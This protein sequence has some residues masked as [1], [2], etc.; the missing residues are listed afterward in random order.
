M[1]GRDIALLL[2][3]SAAAGCGFQVGAGN[4]GSADGGPDSSIDSSIDVAIDAPADTITVLPDG[5]VLTG[6]KRRVK[7]SFKNATRNLALDGFIALVVIDSM[8]VDYTAIKAGGANIRFTD[9]DNTSL[10]YQID[11]WTQGGTS[12]IWVRVP[13]INASSDTDYIYM[14]YG[15]PALNDAQNAAAV[16]AGQQGVWHLSQ[17]PGPGTAAAIRDS[18]P[19][20]RHGTSTLPMV[21]A[22]LV[23]AIIGNGFR[24]PGNGAGVVATA[25]T[26]PTYTWSMW[27]RGVTAPVVA[28]S[29]KEPINNGDVNFNF[30]WDHSLTAYVGAAAQRDAIQ[31]ASVAPGT[32]AAMTWYYLAGTY[33]G[34]NLCSY[35]DGGAGV[36]VAAGAPLAPNGVLMIG[37]AASGTATFNGWIDEVRMTTTAYSSLRLNAEFANQRNAAASPFVV[38]DAP[39]VEP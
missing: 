25:A 4:A 33:D 18:S 28:S 1:C 31:W 2:L 21:T 9:S 13:S 12:Y 27:I 36:C 19:V 22:D 38:F 39:E 20:A 26:M 34:T 8:K 23:P 6:P 7:L 15:D 30:S 24:L 29:N 16:F 5:P 35:R 11:E 17:D 37:H 3:A 10:P 32:L 14:H